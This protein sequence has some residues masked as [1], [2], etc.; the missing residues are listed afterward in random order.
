[1]RCLYLQHPP[2]SS[3]ARQGGQEDQLRHL[4]SE[5]HETLVVK[6]VIF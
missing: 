5:S 2:G 3:A 4:V 1:M 6:R